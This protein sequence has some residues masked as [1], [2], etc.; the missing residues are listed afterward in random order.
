MDNYESDLSDEMFDKIQ[1]IEVGIRGRYMRVSAHTE[2]LLVKNLI[3]LHE[4]KCVKYKLTIPL[5]LRGVMFDDK[6]SMLRSYL[7]R[8]HKDLCK[9]YEKLF[10]H[11]ISF[12][13]VRNNMA[14]SYF[15]WDKNDL[16]HVIIWELQLNVEPHFYKDVKY[17]FNELNQT[18]KDLVAPIMDGLNNL[19][20]D[21]TVRLKPILPYMFEEEGDG[22]PPPET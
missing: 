22:Q 3:L 9:Q 11:L 12:K 17:T 21:L 2:A 16:T 15:T 5:N 20:Y 8:Q 18:F 10:D 19:T 1:K 14:H 7:K 4:E 13:K 6:I